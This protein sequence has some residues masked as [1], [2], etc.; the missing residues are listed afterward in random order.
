MYFPPISKG[1]KSIR[2]IYTITLKRFTRFPCQALTYIEG[3]ECSTGKY[4]LYKDV[5]YQYHFICNR[6]IKKDCGKHRKRR[7]SCLSLCPYRLYFISQSLVYVLALSCLWPLEAVRA[8]AAAKD[9]DTTVTVLRHNKTI[10]QQT[11]DYKA[12][13]LNMSLPCFRLHA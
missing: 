11:T 4:S 12:K 2:S 7:F 6:N 9:S 13:K 1:N 8:L 5:E 3:Y 10:S